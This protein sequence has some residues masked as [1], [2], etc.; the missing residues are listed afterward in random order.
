[1]L[2][3]TNTRNIEDIENYV[4]GNLLVNNNLMAYSIDTLNVDCFSKQENK[5]IYNSMLK[6]YKSN[7]K[8]DMIDINVDLNGVVKADKI[9]SYSNLVYGDVSPKRYSL[10]VDIL[11]ETELRKKITDLADQIKLKLIDRDAPVDVAKLFINKLS[12]V[13]SFNSKKSEKST[14]ELFS[15]LQEHIAKARVHFKEG[16]YV[17]IPSTVIE[18]NKVLGG[19][20]K[21]EVTIVA[22]RPGMGKTAFI[23][24]LING[25]CCIAKKPVL[26]AELEMTHIQLTARIAS[27][28]LEVPADEILQGIHN[29][30][31]FQKLNSVVNNFYNKDE[32]LLYIDDSAGLTVT[33]IRAKASRIKAMHGD[34]GLIIIDYLQLLQAEDSKG[35]R[36]ND[37]SNISR[38]IKRL[39]K[40]LDVPVIALS[41]LSRSVETRADKIPML[42]DLRESGSIEQDAD[43]VIFLYRPYYY[44]LQGLT[45]FSEID[46]S[47]YGVISSEGFAQAIIAKHR[48]GKLKNVS[49]RFID[50]LTKFTDYETYSQLPKSISAMRPNV[51]FSEA[52]SFNEEDD[53]K[54]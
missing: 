26:V 29:D 38:A 4:I 14:T 51:D 7:G 39:A 36:E 27:E 37:I 44:F 54:F 32:E 34:I 17:G 19:A 11:K 43:V 1:M 2:S 22:A 30:V 41:Q 49:M 9:A 33:D 24:T 13:I 46:T 31:V 23:K 45:Q 8:F 47:D 48:N 3:I 21:G 52:K 15:E 5:L 25:C 40:D 53:P 16:G 18:L 10:I 12:D 35:N 50:N 20:R 42:S 28:I 6:L